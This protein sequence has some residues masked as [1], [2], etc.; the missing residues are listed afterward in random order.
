MNVL[1]LVT[2]SNKLYFLKMGGDTFHYNK[3]YLTNVLSKIFSSDFVVSTIVDTY[4]QKCT[5]W[6]TSVNEIIGYYAGI[7]YYANVKL[8]I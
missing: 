8:G 6:Y 5:K 7:T 3:N 4:K 1:F 2:A